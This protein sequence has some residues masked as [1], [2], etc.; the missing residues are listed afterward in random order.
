MS[1]QNIQNDIKTGKNLD[2]H[3]K[4][5]NKFVR[6]WIAQEGHMLDQLI[7]DPAEE[8]RAAVASQGYGL[9]RLINDQSDWVKF[10]AMQALDKV[11]SHNVGYDIIHRIDIGDDHFVVGHNPIAPAPYVTWEFITPQNY[12]YQGH[13]FSDE[14]DALVDLFRRAGE[15]LGFGD[16]SLA[17]QL[18][19][20][21][22]RAK[23]REEREYD[24]VCYALDDRLANSDEAYDR[25]ALL[26]DPKF[27][28]RAICA[29]D[30]IDHSAENE[31]IADA[32][33]LILLDFPQHI[34]SQSLAG[35]F[36]EPIVIKFCPE[37]AELLNDLLKHPTAK[38][39]DIYGPL[40][41]NIEI[42]TDP[43]SDYHVHVE[44]IP[45]YDPLN[46]H[47][48]SET[49]PHTISIAI[50]DKNHNKLLEQSF[51]AL[52]AGGSFPGKYV[53]EQDGQDILTVTLDAD[54]NHRRV[55]KEFLYKS[56]SQDDDN[57]KAHDG[58]TCTIKRGL[59]PK[60][61]DVLITGLMWEA[62]FP[63]GDVLHVFDY[64]LEFPKDR[65][66]SLNE[67]VKNADAK[68]ALQAQ[69]LTD[70]TEPTR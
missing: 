42:S 44:L 69:P 45:S 20:E 7:N 51:T 12:Y 63:D 19:T 56:L 32:L 36:T 1:L 68:Q 13:Y 57:Y 70:R 17:L 43:A 18:L 37:E 54:E 27:M 25:D 40:G 59:T 8:V 60:E 4:S 29:L 39:P 15:E 14:K 41:D 5:D 61:C 67:Q 21:D 62:E 2:V 64:E 3:I 28:Q 46:P 58:Q 26:N 35:I 47:K 23:L 55:G 38:I 52:E 31:A 30:S 48:L 33:D 16:K 65:K 49:E 50:E 34:Q 66:P 53:L 10:A 6:K 9:D 24:A 11:R 22:D